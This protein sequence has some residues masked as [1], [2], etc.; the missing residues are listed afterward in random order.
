[1]EQN[2]SVY[3]ALTNSIIIEY[4]AKIC[5]FWSGVNSVVSFKLTVL[6]AGWQNRSNGKTQFPIFKH[7]LGVARI[8]TFRVRKIIRVI[9]KKNYSSRLFYT[10]MVLLLVII[11]LIIVATTQKMQGKQKNLLLGN[12]ML[13]KNI[14]CHL[15]T[16]EL[17]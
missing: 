1:M 10:G 3:L 16:Q 11:T 13:V 17:G 2:K 12:I 14:C 9:F 5:S 4:S 7:L 15:G 8:V 6:V